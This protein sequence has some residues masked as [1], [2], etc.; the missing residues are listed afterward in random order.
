M[1]SDPEHTR[2]VGEAA[3]KALVLLKKRHP[4][5]KCVTTKGAV[6]NSTTFTTE[7]DSSTSLANN[8]DKILTT[9]L[10]LSKLHEKKIDNKEGWWCPFVFVIFQF[11][12][13]YWIVLES[14]KFF[15]SYLK[16]KCI[17][18]SQVN[19]GRYLGK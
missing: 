3:R 14:F 6:L 8:D 17:F 1:R 7:E 19:L 15:S 12:F 16:L 5:I 2:R 13:E 9:C 10:N 4:N 11:L 18:C